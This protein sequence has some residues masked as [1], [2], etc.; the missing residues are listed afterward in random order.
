MPAT[1]T[2]LAHWRATHPPLLRLWQAHCRMTAAWCD[3]SFRLGLA[4]LPIPKN[5]G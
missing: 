5:R 2:D 3:L 1:I 4:L